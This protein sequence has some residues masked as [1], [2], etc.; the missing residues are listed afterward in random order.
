MISTRN[1]QMMRTKQPSV[2][3]VFS[4]CAKNIV[5]KLNQK[6][7]TICLRGEALKS[8]LKRCSRIQTTAPTKRKKAPVTA[9]ISSVKGLR[10]AH[11]LE[12]LAFTVETMTS[13]DSTYGCVKSTTRVRFV[14]I[15]MSPTVA[16]K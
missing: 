16:S 15:E 13:P 10:K 5:E 2:L 1:S 12:L 7:V 9:H 8:G 14:T 11:S 3:T 4:L 6:M